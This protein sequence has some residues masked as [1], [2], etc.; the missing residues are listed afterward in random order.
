MQYTII[1]YNCIVANNSKIKNKTF[2]NNV[3]IAGTVPQMIK[4]AINWARD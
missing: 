4:R 2:P 3:L 1:D